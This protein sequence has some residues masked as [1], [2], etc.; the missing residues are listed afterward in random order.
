MSFLSPKQQCQS[1]KENKAL[2]PISGLTSSSFLHPPP[3]S[4]QKGQALYASHP[5]PLPNFASFMFYK[6][7]VQWHFWQRCGLYN[8]SDNE[9]GSPFW[10]CIFDKVSTGSDILPECK[11]CCSESK[12]ARRLRMLLPQCTALATINRNY[13][14][15]KSTITSYHKSSISSRIIPRNATF[16]MTTSNIHSNS[17]T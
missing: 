8:N 10:F 5:M 14:L 13:K 16:T 9:T 1:T 12:F 4:R 2:T 6:I 3:D 7:Q 17:E 15:L 11:L